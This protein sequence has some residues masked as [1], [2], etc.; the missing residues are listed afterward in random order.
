[1]FQ[2]AE[3]I[4]KQIDGVVLDATF[5]T[6]QLR[7]RAA[8]IATKHELGFVI[9]QTK[10]PQ[11]VSLK[12]ILLR[13]KDE[14]V[15]NALTELAYFNNKKQFEKVDINN[16]KHI[17]PNLDIFHLIVD[18]QFEQPEDWYITKKIRNITNNKIGRK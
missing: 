15:S 2:Q 5:I 11:A 9:L 3:R 14:Y 18:T 13:T 4:L 12:R 6:H 10:C 16:L 8:A 1:M 17:Y 7:K